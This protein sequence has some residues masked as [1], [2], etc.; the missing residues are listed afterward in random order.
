MTILRVRGRD[1]REALERAR[2]RGGDDAVVVAQE[3][4]PDGSI[5]V[6]VTVPTDSGVLVPAPRRA[7]VRLKVWPNSESRDA[8][9]L[10]LVARLRRNGVSEQFAL[11]I[12]EIAAREGT[13]GILAIDSAARA[14]A[15]C[16]PIAP[17]PKPRARIAFIGGSGAGK[18]SAAGRLAMR[19]GRAGRKVGFVALVD[20]AHR[21]GLPFASAARALGRP[22]AIARER[23]ALAAAFAERAECDIVLV[24]A[25]G[26][27][28]TQPD[29]LA[30]QA[31]LCGA[32]DLGIT[33]YLVLS[34]AL[35]VRVLADQLEAAQALAPMAAV[36][37]RFDETSE[38]GAPIEL[39]ARRALGLALLSRGPL[40]EFDL[41]RADGERAA[42]LLLRG[43]FE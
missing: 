14:I 38:P 34:A 23:G 9:Q 3:A 17:S 29:E 10:E 33:R 20:D 22:I 26:V 12:A 43:K 36:L 24:D 4:L 31:A 15:A 35:S 13:S 6:S 27:E 18:S 25:P 41:C 42:D 28:R 30:L 8:G 2:A 32:E 11:R 1:L 16:V 5:S 21:I 40:Q 19:L 37:T 7:D 39:C